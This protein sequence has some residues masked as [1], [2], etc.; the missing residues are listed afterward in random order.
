VLSIADVWDSYEC[1]D[2]R[3]QAV[4]DCMIA[5]TSDVSDI[6]NLLEKAEAVAEN[7]IKRPEIWRAVL[8]SADRLPAAG[9]FDGKKAASI[10]ELAL[11]SSSD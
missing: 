1:E 11:T 9:R 10:I 3:R 4:Q 8:A 7:L 5:G 2:D 6:G